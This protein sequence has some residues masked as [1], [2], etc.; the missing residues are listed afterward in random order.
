MYRR[1]K[2]DKRMLKVTYWE[3]EKYIK[4]HNKQH[5]QTIDDISKFPQMKRS[6]G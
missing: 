1:G 5:G 4:K 6:R 2:G 3:A